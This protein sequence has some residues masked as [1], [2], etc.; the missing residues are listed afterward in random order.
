[1]TLGK[2]I[3]KI[4]TGLVM[5]GFAILLILIPDIAFSMIVGVLALTLVLYA[6]RSIIFYFSM[7]RHMVG[8][9]RLLIRGV[10]ML[11]L[12][13]FAYSLYDVPR[14]YIVLYLL[15]IHLFAGVVDVLGALDAKKLEAGSWKLKMATGVINIVVGIL[16]LVFIRS[17]TMLDYIY[18]SGLIITALS[19][20]ISAFKRTAVLYVS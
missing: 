4:I 9:T 5:I 19:N 13:L 1:M 20:I 12:G 15:F 7:G 11:D 8:G 18:C 2:R 14:I 16:C 3:L 6:L 17:V 10:I